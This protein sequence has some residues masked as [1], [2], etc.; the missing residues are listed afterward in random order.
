MSRSEQREKSVLSIYAYLSLPRSLYEL[1]EDT[2]QCP[3]E[4]IDPY[5]V[6][7]VEQAIEHQEEYKG[8]L[9]RV[10]ENWTYDRLGTIEKAIL[11]ESCSEFA[12]KEVAAAI[13]IDE[14]V[15]L[16]KTYGEA[17]SYRLVNHVLDII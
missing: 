6:K 4:K 10:L 2:F 17:D 1:M 11:L 8:Y 9:N 12:M 5:F 15:E 14:A 3:L 16:A 13:I 7:V